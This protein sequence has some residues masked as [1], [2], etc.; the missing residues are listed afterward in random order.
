MLALNNTNGNLPYVTHEE[1][2]KFTLPF[3]QIWEEGQTL[4][5][6]FKMLI[7][8]SMVVHEYCHKLLSNV[9]LIN[10]LL[11]EKFDVTIGEY[12]V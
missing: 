7:P 12:I 8:W 9:T 4:L 11:Q 10:E 1:K 2:G 3:V 5:L 6:M